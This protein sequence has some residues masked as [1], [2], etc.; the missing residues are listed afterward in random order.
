MV[1]TIQIADCFIKFR[2]WDPHR[3][4][5]YTYADAAAVIIVY[6]ITNESTFEVA[7]LYVEQVQNYGTEDCLIALVGNKLDKEME[8]KVGKSI[9]EQYADD[10]DLYFIETSA[11]T[12]VSI[13]QLFES[14][15]KQ[16][17]KDIN[18][19]KEINH[20]HD[21]LSNSH[22]IDFKHLAELL[23]NQDWVR[24]NL[25]IMYT[26]GLEIYRKHGNTEK[27][28]LEFKSKWKL[29]KQ[30]EDALIKDVFDKLQSMDENDT[31]TFIH[32]INHCIP[33]FQIEEIDK[34]EE[35]NNNDNQYQ[36]DDQ[37]QDEDQDEDDED[38][39]QDLN[40]I[41]M[42]EMKEFVMDLNVSNQR[43]EEIVDKLQK[44][45]V[46]K[47]WI[48]N[49][50]NNNNEIGMVANKLELNYDEWKSL[51]SYIKKNN[52][53]YNDN[54]NDNYNGTHYSTPK[55]ILSRYDPL[56]QKCI[57]RRRNEINMVS[58]PLI[59]GKTTQCIG[60][61]SLEESNFST[62][63]VEIPPLSS[64]DTEMSYFDEIFFVYQ[65]EKDKV[66][67]KINGDEFYLSSNTNFF[68]PAQ[69]EYSIDNLSKT[70]TAKMY[71]TLVK[72]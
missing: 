8:R 7:K 30:F 32:V 26:L 37:Y 6:D 20:S 40:E 28:L 18:S 15:A 31:N 24:H 33:Q 68:V 12:N 41:E 35:N 27:A 1:N 47:E 50:C 22:E 59:S 67:F 3:E 17:P 63:F 57:L 66:L 13:K 9:G 11:K 43:Y 51:K 25:R 2:I 65:C 70:D 16:I 4:N 10:H 64:K 48:L 23:E 61:K 45:C 55:S 49:N 14:I 60:G 5:L 46:T 29:P 52:D 21:F 62:G 54:D 42:K 69:N 72:T 53:N 58:L 44:K 71:F 34:I 38:M 56:G 39:M 19:S 36:D